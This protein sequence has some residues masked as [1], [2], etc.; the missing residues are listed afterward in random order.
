MNISIGIPVTRTKY[1]LQALQSIAEQ[2]V[3]VHEVIVVDNLADGDVAAIAAQVSLP[4][5]LTKRTHRLPPVENWNRLLAEVSGDW[6]ILLSDDDFFAADHIEQLQEVSMR[7]CGAS[8]LH[9]RVRLVDA[10][11][12]SL[13]LSPLAAEYESALDFLWH[14][15]MGYRVQFLS[16]FAFRTDQLRACGGFCDLPS[17]WGTDDMAVFDV[18]SSYAE[19]PDS[20]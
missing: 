6:F 14:R 1:L 2:T 12:S 9:T 18:R 20:S 4:I 15:A 3:P 13:G 16:D 5:R 11:G 7:H 8:V 17:A 19:L 10:Q